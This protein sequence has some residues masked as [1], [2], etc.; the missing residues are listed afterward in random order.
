VTPNRAR[1][2][3]VRRPARV[4]CTDESKFR[5]RE[6]N[7][8]GA[9]ARIYNDVQ[10]EFLHRRVQIFFHDRIE[11]VDFVDEEHVAFLQIRQHTSQVGGL[12]ENRPGRN[13]NIRSHFIGDNVGE[14]GFAQPGDR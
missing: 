10:P 5:E 12:I 2:G 7:A 14:C 3:A 11:P 1:S 6:L 9:R 13:F 4:V 8:P